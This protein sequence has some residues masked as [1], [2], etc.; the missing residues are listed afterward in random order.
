MER[1][2]TKFDS[3]LDEI[4][5]AGVD[6]SELV[7]FAD[8]SHALKH[9]CGYIARC[10]AFTKCE[11]CVNCLKM[12]PN[13]EQLEFINICDQFGLIYYPTNELTQLF[14]SVETAIIQEVEDKNYSRNPT[15]DLGKAVGRSRGI[16]KIGMWKF[17][18]QTRT[19]LRNFKIFK[20]FKVVFYFKSCQ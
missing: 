17:R 1:K 11:S 14:S 5:D 8:V 18:A 16:T 15:P 20:G 3:L 9:F 2:K 7:K 10:S 12:K 6:F 4:V 19:D 13:Q